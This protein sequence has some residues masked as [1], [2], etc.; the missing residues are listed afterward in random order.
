MAKRTRQLPISL[1]RGV[2][3]VKG[4]DHGYGNEFVNPSSLVGLEYAFI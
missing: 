1:K 4:N 3:F 2:W